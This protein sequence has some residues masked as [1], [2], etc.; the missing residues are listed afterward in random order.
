[1]NREQSVCVS[2]IIKSKQLQIAGLQVMNEEAEMVKVLWN[3]PLSDEQKNSI[4]LDFPEVQFVW[5]TSKEPVEELVQKA[6]GSEVMVGDFP[7][8]LIEGV[9]AKPNRLQWV[10]SWFAGVNML[11]LS[12]LR[13]NNIIVTRAGGVSVNPMSE[14]VIA[15]MIMLS[16]DFKTLLTQQN[17]KIWKEGIWPGEIHNKT[18]GILGLGAIGSGLARAAKGFD[19]IVWGYQQTP[20]ADFCADHLVSEG[21]LDDLLT[22]SDFVVNILPLT[23]RTANLM[24]IRRFSKMKDSAYYISIGRGGTTVTAD[25]VEALKTG[26]IK[27]AGLDVFDIEPLPEDNPLWDMDQVIILPHQAG[28]TSEYHA[29]MIEIASRNLQE[30][31]AFGKPGQFVVNA[32]KG[33]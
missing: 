13:E 22:A 4:E 16:R 12:L 30:Y 8:G 23:P 17:E 25:L 28:L 2:F 9:L 29:R 27:G 15:L 21:Q 31:L 26:M 7:P 11:P 14:T 32:A 10:Q 3:W 33:Y 24:D 1:M 5:S 20:K 6:E 19:M 18:V